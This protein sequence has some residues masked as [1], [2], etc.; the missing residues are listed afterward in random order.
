[1]L[2]EIFS[3]LSGF[4]IVLTAALLSKRVRK[5]CEIKGPLA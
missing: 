3:W 5:I 4:E 2:C 1:M